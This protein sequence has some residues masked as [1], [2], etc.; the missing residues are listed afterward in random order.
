MF[1]R[2]DIYG[3]SE[4]VSFNHAELDLVWELVHDHVKHMQAYYPTDAHLDGLKALEERLYDALG[5]V[6]R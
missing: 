3:A 4:S 2:H 6:Q 1:K 5:R